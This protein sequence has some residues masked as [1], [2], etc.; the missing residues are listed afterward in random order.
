MRAPEPQATRPPAKDRPLLLPPHNAAVQLISAAREQG[1]LSTARWCQD[2]PSTEIAAAVPPLRI[3]RSRAASQSLPGGRETSPT[4]CWRPDLHRIELTIWPIATAVA[5]AQFRARP[6]LTCEA[7]DPGCHGGRCVGIATILHDVSRAL[8]SA[9]GTLPAIAPEP[10][11]A[12]GRTGSRVRCDQSGGGR[13]RVA[14]VVRSQQ[15]W[16]VPVVSKS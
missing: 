5:F 7:A 4:A 2:C 8:L 14:A 9:T 16:M 3:S 1:Q 13:V 15:P 12:R 6:W 11:P 10:S